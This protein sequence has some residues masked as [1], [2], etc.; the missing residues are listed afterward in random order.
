MPIYVS[1]ITY[2]LDDLKPDTDYLV[3]VASRNPSGLSDWM[4]PQDFRTHKAAETGSATP[5]FGPS[6]TITM[7][8]QLMII[9]I[10][11]INDL[12]HG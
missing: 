1:G 4:G 6:F 11:F 10:V 9:H 5:S 7:F 8:I 3:R 2:M 12:L